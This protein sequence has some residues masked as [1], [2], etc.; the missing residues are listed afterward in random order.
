MAAHEQCVADFRPGVCIHIP[1]ASQLAPSKRSDSVGVDRTYV[2]P[3]RRVSLLVSRHRA[4]HDALICPITEATIV[5][6]AGACGV[7]I[8]LRRR[9][10]QREVSNCQCTSGCGADQADEPQLCTLPGSSRRSSTPTGP[11]SG[12]PRGQQRA[13][14]L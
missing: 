5:F 6:D 8:T 2:P 3:H 4:Q 13:G 10:S 11:R 14:H 7:E 9:I 12:L 1:H